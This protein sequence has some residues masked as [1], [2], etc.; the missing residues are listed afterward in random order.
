MHNNDEWKIK[1]NRRLDE[2]ERK[3]KIIIDALRTLTSPPEPA[4]PKVPER[5]FIG[6]EE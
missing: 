1:V 4:T 2:I 5:S 6:R 3:Q